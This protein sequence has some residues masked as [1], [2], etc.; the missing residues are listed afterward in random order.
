[1]ASPCQQSGEEILFV[2]V[3]VQELDISSDQEVSGAR[4]NLKEAL[5]DLVKDTDVDSNFS[6][7]FGETAFVQENGGE[8]QIR[9]LPQAFQQGRKLDF[10]S[11]PTVTGGNVTNSELCHAG[12]RPASACLSHAGLAAN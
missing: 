9:G 5:V 3:R 7:L 11:G 6:R 10:G 4:K 1:V 2:T 12:L 8:A